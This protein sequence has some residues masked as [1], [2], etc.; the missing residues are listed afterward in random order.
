MTSS[1]AAAR[2]RR[3]SISQRVRGLVPRKATAISSARS[4]SGASRGCGRRFRDELATPAPDL[5]RLADSL[6]A[7]LDA[8]DLPAD[9]VVDLLGDLGVLLQ[10]VPGVLTTLAE[11]DIAVVEPRPGLAED[12]GRDADVEQAAFDADA[13]RCT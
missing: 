1:V 8:R 6:R 2:R 7:D 10:E 3:R 4:P 5:L 11:A 13:P 9:L 12:A